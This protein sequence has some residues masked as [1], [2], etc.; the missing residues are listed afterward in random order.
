MSIFYHQEI[1]AYRGEVAGSAGTSWGAESSA[2]ALST[3][4]LQKSLEGTP[5]Q[6]SRQFWWFSGSL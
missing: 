2:Q 3:C 5:F 1:R 6:R 4:R